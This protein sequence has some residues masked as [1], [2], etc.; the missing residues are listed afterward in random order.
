M[1]YKAFLIA[2][3]FLPQFVFA[4][5]QTYSTP[6][7]YTFTVPTSYATLTVQVWGGGGGGG[8]TGANGDFGNINGQAGSSSSFNG[9]IIGYGGGGGRDNY[10]Y[11]GE[12]S[13]GSASGGDVNTQGGSSGP[14]MPS[15][16][17]G[18]VETGG[19]SPNGGSGGYDPNQCL[20][21]NNSM[22]AA[23]APGGGG[24]GGACIATGGG[25]GGYASK[26]YS[27]GQLTPGT[28]ITVVVGNGGAGYS[29]APWG[30][31]AIHGG[32]GASGRVTITWTDPCPTAAPSPWTNGLLVY[33]GGTYRI[34]AQGYNFC[35]ANSSGYNYYV[36]VA[37][38]AELAAFVGRIPYLSGL[39]TF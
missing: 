24:G 8:S 37:T 30:Y 4:G 7:T 31:P 1:K 13:G 29:L 5:S 19:T 34:N 36:P 6:G 3:L 22:V 25:G 26:T 18:F 23:N 2:T 16:F 10:S 32:A 11:G 27:V 38:A 39:T 35:I 15:A 12:V 21:G 33:S 17:G 9:T 28:A 20:G 14:F